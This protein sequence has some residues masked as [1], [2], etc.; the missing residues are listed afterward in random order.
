MAHQI[1]WSPKAI[2]HLAE[3]CG[4]ISADSPYYAS[5]FAQRAVAL[6]ERLGLFPEMGR[7]VPEYDNPNLRELIHQN[8]R[9]VYRHIGQAVEVAAIVHAARM[10]T[11]VLGP[12]GDEP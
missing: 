10:L 4:L 8:Y 6:I 9:I 11:D 2:S 5:L 3:I 1:R 12:I 7:V